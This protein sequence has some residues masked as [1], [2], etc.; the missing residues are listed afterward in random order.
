LAAAMTSQAA[1]ATEV[2]VNIGL[3]P[4]AFY[5]PEHLDEDEP[6]PFYGLRLHVK[7]VIN[8]DVVK[9]HKDKIPAQYRSTV[10]KLDEVRVGYLL[11]PESIMLGTRKKAHGPEIYGAT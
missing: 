10:E 6:E 11:I 5:I 4:A 2:P 1:M 3:G 7:A 9:R 8:R